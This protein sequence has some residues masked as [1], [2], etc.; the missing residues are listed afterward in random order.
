ME[1]LAHE[2]DLIVASFTRLEVIRGMREHERERTMLLL[3]S[4]LTHPLDV[5]TADRAGELMREQLARRKTIAGSDAVIAATA[6]ICNAALVTINPAHF[7]SPGLK[8]YTVDERARI[9]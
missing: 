9:S 1:R 8:L 7:P 4:L 2:G 6:F 5:P 3:N